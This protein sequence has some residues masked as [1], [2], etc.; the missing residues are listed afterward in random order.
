VRVGNTAVVC[1]VRAE[2]LTAEEGTV[3]E[4]RSLNNRDEDG[5]EEQDYKEIQDL[6]LLVPN[7]ELCTG[8][9][10]ALLPGNAPS[11]FAQTLVT[12]I[13][14]LLLST[15]VIGARQ[16]RITHEGS[17]MGDGDAGGPNLNQE[18]D[19]AMQE[20]GETEARERL[21]KGYWTLYIDTMFISLDGNAFDAA[22]LAILSALANTR[23][24]KAYFDEELEMILCSDDPAEA[25]KLELTGL[26]VP[27]TFAVFES[28][29][30]WAEDDDGD[31]DGEG[32]S[33]VLSDPDA[34]EESV[35]RE[36]VTV[37]VDCSTSA[38]GQ[39]RKIEK[40]G[41]GVVER[42]V[43]EM[44]VKRTVQRWKEWEKTLSAN[45]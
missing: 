16:L 26:P 34:F 11:A 3:D 8:S 40:S 24:P 25:K 44:L 35:C 23:L 17:A 37:I 43:M 31:R 2:I 32:K 1:G 18:G 33:W 19:E 27:S 36:S 21:V 30:R 45:S 6:R 22:W 14:N 13:R 29:G 42:D 10:P 39:I 20:D 12:R 4:S 7:I 5:G 9:T 15:R 28:D 41:G 38:K